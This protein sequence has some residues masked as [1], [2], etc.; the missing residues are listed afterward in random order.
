M[1]SKTF[2][3]RHLVVINCQPT[4]DYLIKTNSATQDQRCKIAESTKRGIYED[5]L[6]ETIASLAFG[7]TSTRKLSKI[8]IHIYFWFWWHTI[9]ML[10]HLNTFSSLLKSSYCYPNDH[11]SIKYNLSGV[12]NFCHLSDSFFSSSWMLDSVK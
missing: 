10:H 6:C 8:E 1:L 7:G 3:W 5:P 9:F 2:F 11:H 4:H 12:V